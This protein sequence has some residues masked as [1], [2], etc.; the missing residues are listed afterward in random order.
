MKKIQIRVG[1]NTALGADRNGITKIIVGKYRWMGFEEQI[2]PL[3]EFDGNFIGRNCGL[4][5]S[6]DA[7]EIEFIHPETM[8]GSSEEIRQDLL[9]I[10]DKKICG[11]AEQ[12]PGN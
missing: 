11:P 4:I 8:W 9:R 10:A 3:D 7:I 12:D 6:E 1:Q 5:S 2:E